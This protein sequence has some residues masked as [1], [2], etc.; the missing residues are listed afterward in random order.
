[1]TDDVK[2]RVAR[3]LAVED[4]ASPDLP[5][6][7][8]SWFCYDP[9]AR[10]ALSALRPGDEINGCV[11][12]PKDQKPSG[13]LGWFAGA[14]SENSYREFTRHEETAR[15][16]SVYAEVTPLYAI[17]ALAAAKETMK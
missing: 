16:W 7:E 11:L 9:A 2:E 15:R 6:D 13:W 4:G 17:P 14:G 12:V 1:M 3:A 10:A 8:P 5:E